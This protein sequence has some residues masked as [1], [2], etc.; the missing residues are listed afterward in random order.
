MTWALIRLN[1][2]FRTEQGIAIAGTRAL[3]WRDVDLD[4]HLHVSEL[5]G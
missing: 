1:L 5:V 4:K 3:E 2:L